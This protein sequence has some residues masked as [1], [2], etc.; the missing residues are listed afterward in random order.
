MRFDCIV[1]NPPYGLRTGNIHLKVLKATLPY[2]TN[3]LVFIMP[4]KPLVEESEW[5]SML[6]E[7]V[8]VGVEVMSEE[9][10]PDTDM[11]ATAIYTIDR[12][13]DKD[14]YCR[15]LDV[16]YIVYNMIDHPSH[17]LYID[18]MNGGL[19]MYSHVHGMTPAEV[20][21][22]KRRIVDDGWYLNINRAN[23]TYDGRWL[24]GFLN[25]L[26][27]LDR[28]SEVDFITGKMYNI[29]YCPTKRYGDNLKKLLNCPVLKYGLWLTQSNRFI[30]DRQ[31]RYLPDIDYDTIDTDQK[32]LESVGFTP[33]EISGMIDYLENFD[34]RKKRN[35]LIR[36]YNTQGCFKPYS[37][38]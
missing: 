32:I 34:F 36:N 9:V 38:F 11:E 3:K 14:T 29:M 1:G 6:R 23:G 22:A 16:D 24:S 30:L 27:I 7:A 26:P 10:F 13:A 12:K 35:D 37:Y 19:K 17:R 25:R 31:F 4:S 5:N 33:D 15:R 28:D 2:C 21:A 20:R 8:C 18:K